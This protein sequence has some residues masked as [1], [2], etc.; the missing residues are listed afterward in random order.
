MKNYLLAGALLAA[1]LTLAWSATTNAQDA[2]IGVLR[3]VAGVEPI[4]TGGQIAV[5][6][7]SYNDLSLAIQETITQALTR[8]GYTVSIG[9][10]LL[11]VFDFQQNQDA[12]S[13]PSGAIDSGMQEETAVSEDEDEEPGVDLGQQ[14]GAGDAPQMPSVII[15]Y[16][17]GGGIVMRPSTTFNLDLTL[18]NSD[19]PPLW[20]GSMTAAL[21]TSDPVEAARA[22]VPELISHLGKTV[23]GLR[24]ILKQP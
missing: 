11:L 22:L 19:A 24:V 14:G 16:D 15:E 21:P 3:A 8:Q 1:L 6:S 20:Q 7:Q 12:G 4:P 23:P 10:P 18:G 17:F 2:E 5:T 9:A 13:F